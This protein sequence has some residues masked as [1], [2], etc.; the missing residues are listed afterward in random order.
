MGTMSMTT[1]TTNEP[2]IGFNYDD[3]WRNTSCYEMGLAGK[4]IP[5]NYYHFPPEK[6]LNA[7]YK[8][9][10]YVL[11][12]YLSPLVALLG[13]LMNLT[14]L[15]VLARVRD[16]R[17]VTNVYLGNLAVADAMFLITSAVDLLKTWQSNTGLLLNHPYY[18]NAQC[19][20]FNLSIKL[21]F[22]GSVCM[23]TL[24]AFER[25]MAICHPLK[26]R[27]VSGRRYTIMVTAVTWLVAVIMG[28]LGCLKTVRSNSFCNL[29]PPGL[30]EIADVYIGDDQ[31]VCAPL[32]P[33]W[34]AVSDW[35]QSVF[36]IANLCLNIIL[37]CSIIRRLG[38]RN[39]GGEGNQ[40]RERELQRVQN[41]VAKMLIINGV[42]FLILM[43]PYEINT[44]V[45]FIWTVTW[46]LRS[47]EEATAIRNLEFYGTCLRFINSALNPIIYGLSNSRYR[48]AYRKAFGCAR[49]ERKQPTSVDNKTAVLTASTINI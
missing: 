4:A 25:Y 1:F 43:V 3:L 14:F 39:F 16:M 6:I 31:T 49:K 11:K 28:T 30:K 18:T 36:F 9:H 32:S 29:W 26:H 38:K 13:I 34:E 19:I 10:N 7:F 5:M 23:I 27:M 22:Y 15:F 47:T 41:Q 33:V 48:Q 21:T 45:K 46:H 37:Y 2:N 17:T 12:F 24:V 42:V 20:S 8:Q 40:E 35:M 44:F